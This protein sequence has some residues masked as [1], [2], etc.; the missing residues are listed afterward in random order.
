MKTKHIMLV[1]C[2][3]ALSMV[4]PQ[5]FAA[6]KCGGPYG[7]IDVP[8]GNIAANGANKWITPIGATS[9]WKAINY[10]DK[11]WDSEK[12][13]CVD[14]SIPNPA[15]IKWVSTY[16][17]A[18]SMTGTPKTLTAA[19]DPRTNVAVKLEL[20]DAGTP[21]NDGGFTQVASQSVDIVIP[22]AG[23]TSPICNE[24]RGEWG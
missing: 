2:L 6:D 16:M 12:C 10:G 9:T 14:D 15:G 11:D 3:C 13:K 17:S 23:N 21:I 5:T 18:A 19:T 4:S 7:S 20:D 22:N 1:S 8:T 24:L